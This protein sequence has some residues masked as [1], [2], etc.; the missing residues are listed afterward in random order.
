LRKAPNHVEGLHL[1]GVIAH[2]RGRHQQAVQLISRSP[3]FADAH[4][5]L[6]AALQALGRLDE[7]SASYRTAIELK[8][9]AALAHCNLSTLLNSQGL[10]EEALESARRALELMPRHANAHLNFAGALAG[11]HRFAEAELAYRKALA[12]EPERAETLWSG[13]GHMLLTLGRFDE[14]RACFHRALE[15]DPERPDADAGLAFI[16]QGAGDEEQLQPLRKLLASP[17]HPTAVRSKAG[18]RIERSRR[19]DVA[20]TVVRCQNPRVEDAEGDRRC[21]L[22]RAR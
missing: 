17:D 8:P 21:R 20:N 10:F 5:N 22:A 2:E 1:L 16:G 13:L 7:A 9:D 12:L 14:A 11:L 15:L 4:L 18:V 3:G 19:S 6:G